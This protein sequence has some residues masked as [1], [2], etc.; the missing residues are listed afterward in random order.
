MIVSVRV[1]DE[2]G[3]QFLKVKNTYDPDITASELI[4]TL[5]ES[6]IINH[7]KKGGHTG[8]ANIIKKAHAH[9]QELAT[10]RYEMQCLFMPTNTMRRIY[11]MCRQAQLMS[12]EPDIGIIGY[13]VGM[14]ERL[15]KLSPPHI[16]K[17]LK[18]M[19][20]QFRMLN[21]EAKIKRFVGLHFPT[22]QMLEVYDEQG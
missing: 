16:Q 11:G 14:A 21:S 22:T 19:M 13:V 15:F 17:R 9:R 8:M 1:P 10:Q 3:D 7:A 18:P 12:M 2:V 20:A 6:Y 5:I 4:R